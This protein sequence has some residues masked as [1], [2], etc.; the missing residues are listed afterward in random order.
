M[1]PRPASDGVAVG[2]GRV[3]L[4]WQAKRVAE[5]KEGGG[6]GKRGGWEGQAWR[7]EG[8]SRRQKKK[9]EEKAEPC[10]ET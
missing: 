5:G 3:G 7:G 1:P 9:K 2:D 6:R 10:P 4:E 8:A